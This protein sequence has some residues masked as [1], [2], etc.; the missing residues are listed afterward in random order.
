MTQKGLINKTIETDCALAVSQ[1]G[2]FSHAP[3]KKLHATTV[4]TIITRYLY[5][6]N[7][8]GMIGGPIQSH[9]L[10]RDSSFAEKYGVQPAESRVSVKSQNRSHHLLG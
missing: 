4:K 1:A 3:P 8:K 2:H 10:E 6:T 7:N 9:Q 5:R